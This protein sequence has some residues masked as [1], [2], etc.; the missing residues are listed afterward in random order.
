MVVRSMLVVEEYVC[1]LLRLLGFLVLS[2]MLAYVGVCL[3]RPHLSFPGV[4]FVS[5]LS[6]MGP[7]ACV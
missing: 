4:H 7:D 1:V 3:R 5:R 6:A 2:P